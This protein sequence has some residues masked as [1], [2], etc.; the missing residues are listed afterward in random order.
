VARRFRGLLILA[1]AL[2]PLIACSNGDGAGEAQSSALELTALHAEPDVENGGRIVDARG[3]EVLLRG[4]NV[5]ALAEY[6]KG[7]EFPT[8]F[9][10]AAGDP[11]RMQSIGWSAVRLLVSWSRIEPAPGRYD[12]DYLDDVEQT[13]TR[14]KRV[15]LYSIVDFHQDAW[16]PETA[17]RENEECPPN[18]E[19]GLGWDGAPGW[20]TLDGGLP[21]CTS[22]A[23]EINPATMRAWQAFFT[24]EAA[25]D[26]VGIQTRYVA[27]LGHVAR[28]FAGAP[29]VAGYDLMNEPNSFSPAD[30]DRLAAMYGKAIEAIRKAERAARGFSHLVFFEPSALFS[31]TGSGAPPSFTRDTNVVYA[32]HIYTG[33]FTNGPITRDAF[34]TARREAAALGGVPVLSG[35]WGTGPERADDPTDRYFLEHQELQD[36]FFAGATLWTWRESCGDPHKVADF[37][38]GR[39]PT[40]WGEFEVDC[41]DNSVGAVRDTLIAQLRRGYVRA[42]PGVLRATAWDHDGGRLDASGRADRDSPLL[43]FHPA[44]DVKVTVQG[45][46]SVNVESLAGG[47]VLITATPTGGRWSIRAAADPASGE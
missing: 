44:R 40:V 34:E 36:E 16:G 27:M 17:A 32:P 3:R 15:G 11:A 1:A 4:V 8:T 22:G 14:L 29:E 33:G 46:E 19:L 35:E 5:N 21:R 37:R 31:A 18:T 28:R 7:T 2:S 47:G 43:A 41:R 6:W 20:A 23:R 13:V 12:E 25:A 26:G 45:L 38:A 39:L 24:D 30:N 10:L 42:A 9:P